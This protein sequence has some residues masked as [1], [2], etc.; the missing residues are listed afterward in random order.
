MLA[1]HLRITALLLSAVQLLLL[2]R[3]TCSAEN[4]DRHV[5]YYPFCS[6]N[7]WIVPCH[8]LA[9]Q[10]HPWTSLNATC[11]VLLPP[12]R[13][14]LFCVRGCAS[15]NAWSWGPEADLP[16]IGVT[17]LCFP[18]RNLSN[19]SPIWQLFCKLSAK[20]AAKC[21][22]CNFQAQ[23]EKWSWQIQCSITEGSDMHYIIADL[24]ISGPF[25]FLCLAS[26]EEVSLGWLFLAWR[27]M[28]V[29]QEMAM[30][31]TSWMLSLVCSPVW[32]IP[33]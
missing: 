11:N 32:I 10:D 8:T 26:C 17:A 30:W 16:Q 9:N 1:V 21:Y 2:S 14:Q 6:F 5:N 4:I 19:H 24:S 28:P 18:F 23:G 7:V 31:W 15:G 27:A 22:H 3:R 25:F 33:H 29:Y 13:G 20:L 12:D